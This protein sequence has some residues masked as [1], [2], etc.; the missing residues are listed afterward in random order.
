MARGRDCGCRATRAARAEGAARES[1]PRHARPSRRGLRRRP[2]MKSAV[3][4]A[5]FGRKLR[6]HDIS[7][8]DV[9]NAC[10][11]AIE[12]DNPRLNAFILVMA[13]Q[14]RQRAAEADRE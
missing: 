5:E 4:I 10:L 6:S 9:T 14:A 7:A 13:D 8:L 2:S 3:T 12:A 1:G 11:A